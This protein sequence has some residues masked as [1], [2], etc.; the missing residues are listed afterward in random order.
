MTVRR[1]DRPVLGLALC[2]AV[3]VGCVGGICP[4]LRERSKDQLRAA[5]GWM[6]PVAQNEIRGTIHPDELLRFAEKTRA[7]RKPEVLPPR[8]TVLVISGGGA[9]GAYPAGVLCGWTESGA[10]PEFDV[11]TGVSTGALIACYAFMG[12]TFDADLKRNYT[13]VSNDDIYRIRRLPFSLLAESLADNTPLA[14]LIAQEVTDERIR[15]VAAQHARGRRL[16]VG[17]S[18][19]DTRRAVV[20][21]MGAIATRGDRDLFRAV[22][23]ASAA[24]PGFFPPVRIPVT[25][26][27]VP[28]VERHIDGGTSSS[29]F[30]V[31]PWVPPDQRANL[32]PGWLY[33]SDLYI[34][35]AGKL[36]ADPA[37]VRLRT[38]AIAQHAVSTIV[39]DQ[40]RSDLHKLY[41]M[42]LLTGMNFHLASIPMDLEIHTDAT[43][44]DPTQMCRMFQAGAA[45]GRTN[46]RW[47]D[48]PPGY[49]PGE[50]SRY[51]VGTVLTATGGTA[52]IG[53]D[54]FPVPVIP[55]KK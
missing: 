28:H 2:A 45:W 42:S 4:E 51:R 3:A 50:G 39:Y 21:D 32:P 31:P 22:L 49:E 43:Q 11:V 47:R 9:F 17:T 26:D 48:T 35:V 18:D 24:I 27:G 20:W 25:V 29:M 10:R 52:V 13:T 36:Y 38:L 54:N 16:Y 44:F 14:R 19:L 23:L 15:L 30:F 40:T 53:G 12:P 37:P 6:D 46:P 33:N 8:R 55:E 5:T 34:L 7:A 41:L 1:L